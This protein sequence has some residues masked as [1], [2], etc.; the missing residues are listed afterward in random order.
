VSERVSF[1]RSVGQSVGWLV[2]RSVSKLGSLPR[3]S[4]VHFVS[5]R[6]SLVQFSSFQLAAQSLT[7]GNKLPWL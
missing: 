4:L 5:V 2:G 7:T 3:F 1:G 6:F